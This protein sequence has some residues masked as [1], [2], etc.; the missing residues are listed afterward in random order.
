MLIYFN[1][2]QKKEALKNLKELLIQNGTL[3]IGH[4]D[5]SFEPDGF[6]KIHTKNGTYLQKRS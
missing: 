4:A 6:S 2:I 3:F 5:I 1:E